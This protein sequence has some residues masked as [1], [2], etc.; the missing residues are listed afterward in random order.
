MVWSLD[1]DV[2]TAGL[3]VW[4]VRGLGVGVLGGSGVR[5]SLEQHYHDRA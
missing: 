3:R 1:F 2:V 4:A 5:A